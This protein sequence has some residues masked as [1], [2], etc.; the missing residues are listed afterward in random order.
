M[1]AVDVNVQA[2][3]GCDAGIV[4]KAALQFLARSALWRILR[5]RSISRARVNDLSRGSPRRSARLNQSA[6]SL[7][8]DT[9]LGKSMYLFSAI[10]RVTTHSC[11][12]PHFAQVDIRDAALPRWTALRLAGQMMGTPCLELIREPPSI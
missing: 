6:P 1:P 12:T 10:I 7:S 2:T 11:F 3:L 4:A 8:V 5:C 9:N